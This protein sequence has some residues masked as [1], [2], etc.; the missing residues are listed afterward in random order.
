MSMIGAPT[1]YASWLHSGDTAWQLTAA[2]LVGL[3]STPGLALLYAGLA[4]KRW[5][6]NTM[7]MA[8]S[9]FSIVLIVWLLWGFNLAFGN[10]IH[11][12]SGL[13]D[14]FSG[15]RAR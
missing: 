11:L 1:P 15:I 13:G 3:M 2:T 14:R 8:F 12:G 7:T 4:P 5:A 9:R 10:P 6:V